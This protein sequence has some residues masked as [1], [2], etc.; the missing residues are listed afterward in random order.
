[1]EDN[2][3]L[4]K[5]MMN[6]PPVISTTKLVKNFQKH[7]SN[8]LYSILLG[9]IINLKKYHKLTPLTAVPK[10]MNKYSVYVDVLNDLTNN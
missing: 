2:L 8:Q 9:D 5:R 10:P 7:Q 6:L 3:K 1:M 4:A